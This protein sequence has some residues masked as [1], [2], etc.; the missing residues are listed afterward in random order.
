MQ[1]VSCQQDMDRVWIEIVR[2]AALHDVVKVGIPDAV[3][4]PLLVAE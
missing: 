3:L 4:L 2:T 1:L